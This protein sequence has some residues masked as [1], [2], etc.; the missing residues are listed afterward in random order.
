MFILKNTNDKLE[1]RNLSLQREVEEQ[2]RKKKEIYSKAKKLKRLENWAAIC[3][4]VLACFD[5]QDEPKLFSE[6]SSQLT[7]LNSLAKRPPE[8]NIGAK[9]SLPLN[10]PTKKTNS[11]KPPPLLDLNFSKSSQEDQTRPLPPNTVNAVPLQKPVRLECAEPASQPHEQNSP[12]SFLSK[13]EQSYNY[14]KKPGEGIANLISGLKPKPQVQ[15]PSENGTLR[16]NQ[17]ANSSDKDPQARSEE[18]LII[19]HS[20]QPHPATPLP[21]DARWDSISTS[22]KSFFQTADRKSNDKASN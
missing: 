22:F 2:K 17:T 7:T 19:E 8:S 6:L 3:D 11:E 20:E 18:E 14:P 16:T 10:L 15:H 12:F 21:S 1:K 9:E 13:M 4:D 5:S